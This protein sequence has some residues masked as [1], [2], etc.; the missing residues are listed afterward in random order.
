LWRFSFPVC[1][2]K[3]STLKSAEI[4]PLYKKVEVANTSNYRTI[5][6]LTSFSKIV[7]KIIYTRLIRHLNHNH[8][9]VYEQFGFRTTSSTDLASCQLIK[10]VQT[11]LNK[12]SV[13]GVF[14]D[15][16]KAFDCV[17]ND[18]VLSKLNWCGI[19]GKEYKL[20]SS[21]LKNRY[22]RVIIT[23]KSKWYY[24]KWE[25]TRYG[26]PQ[27]SI[28][29]PLFFI[30]YINDFP[31]PIA[32]LANPVLCADDTSMII[33]K[34]D[35]KEFINTI[36]RNIIKINEC[37]K[38]NSLSLRVDKTYI[39]QFHT[40]TNQKYDFQTSYENRKLKILNFSG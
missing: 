4:K 19:S 38:S 6:L 20:L 5:S 28:L 26:I 14:G 21:Y 35:P 3:Y 12:L 15:L 17:D 29:G 31:K 37:F 16:Q 22:H 10:D 27:V 32:S 23:N 25:P 7:E 11:S 13:G 2:Y 1:P 8:I 18:I 33:S 30:L 24:S 36:N 9:L 34:S 40:K 39:L